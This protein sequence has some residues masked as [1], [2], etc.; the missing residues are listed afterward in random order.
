MKLIDSHA[1]LDFKDFSSDLDSV[2]KRADGV[3]VEK[4]INIGADLDR[5]KKSIQ[6]AENYK[7]IWSTIG[8]HPEEAHKIKIENSFL[9]LEK[10][11]SS[12]DKIVAIG[13]CGIDYFWSEKVADNVSAKKSQSRLFEGQ[14]E[15][16]KKHGMPVV[17]HIRNANDDS[18]VRRAYD[19]LISSGVKRGVVHCF[20]LDS[21]WARKFIE[22]GLYISFTGIITYKNAEDIC[23]AVRVIPLE[24]ILVETDC[25]FLAPQL[26]RG[27][28]NEPAYVVEVANKISD[29]KGVS[30]EKVS[31]VTSRN[32]ENLFGI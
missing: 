22:Y 27:K 26:H 25:P 24:K 8:I 2:I 1:H 17:I 28:R 7:N 32:T 18:A 23:E 21:H 6:I 13:E 15:L 19:I 14:L 30:F 5:S 16:A 31:E 11:L 9:E 3:G 10:L 29:L 4:I 20:T 12:S